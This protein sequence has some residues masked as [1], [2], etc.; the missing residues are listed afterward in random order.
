MVILIYLSRNSRPEIHFVLHQ[1]VLI[2]Q[3]LPCP[4][5]GLGLGLGLVLCPNLIDTLKSSV[6]RCT[7]RILSEA[8]ILKG[9]DYVQGVMAEMYQPF[10]MYHYVIKLIEV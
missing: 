5:L 10:K 9:L 4:L 6:L 3:L 7:T 8:S 2:Q 1:C